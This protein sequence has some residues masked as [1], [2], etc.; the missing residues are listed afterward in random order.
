MSDDCP[1][2]SSHGLMIQ[3]ARLNAW[4]DSVQRFILL[5]KNL[6]HIISIFGLEKAGKTIA[7]CGIS[8]LGQGV[9]LQSGAL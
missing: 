7:L 2:D 1:N 5:N 6:E 9:C 3:G 4:K 8:W